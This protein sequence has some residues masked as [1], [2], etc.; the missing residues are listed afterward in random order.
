MSSFSY[1]AMGTD[2]DIQ[3]SADKWNNILS[4]LLDKICIQ[5]WKKDY[6]NLNILD[7]TQWE[8]TVTYE[9]KKRK[10]Y[11]GSNAYPPRWE[12]FDRIFSVFTEKRFE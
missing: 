6:V 5:E 4:E 3:I 7:G 11:G 8:F 10:S 12:E 2:K 9:G 1:S